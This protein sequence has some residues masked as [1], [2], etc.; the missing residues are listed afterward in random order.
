MKPI[1]RELEDNQDGKNDDGNPCLPEEPKVKK[2]KEEDF[3]SYIAI[4]SDEGQVLQLLLSRNCVDYLPFLTLTFLIF[5]SKG[6]ALPCSS[7]LPLPFRHEHRSS[8]VQHA[9]ESRTE[10]GP[11]QTP[12]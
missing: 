1:K 9:S 2:I 4:L 12:H 7:F 6:V 5:S 11:H 8:F 3:S 10:A